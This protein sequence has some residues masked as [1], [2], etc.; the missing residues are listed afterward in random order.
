MDGLMGLFAL[1]SLV[2]TLTGGLAMAGSPSVL[3]GSSAL[4]FSLPAMNEDIALELVNKPSVAL[5]DFAGFDASYPHRVT[6]L[7][8][9]TRSAGGEGLAALDQLARRYRGKDVQVV[10]I[11][12][13]PGQMAPLSDWITGLALSYPVLRDHHKVVAGRYGI[14]EYPVTY[15]VDAEGEVFAAG[16]PKGAELESELSAAVEAALTERPGN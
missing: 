4:Q 8:F 2:L 11:L 5:S 15:V 16:N 7:Y 9:C 3:P 13:D 1:V 10:A 12:S 6:V 14:S